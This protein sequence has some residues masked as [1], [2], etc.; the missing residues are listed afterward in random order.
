MCPPNLCLYIV[1]NPPDDVESEF[2]D[3]EAWFLRILA[4]TPVATT[5][6][7]GTGGELPGDLARFAG[8]VVT[9][10]PA[11]L[12]EPEPWMEAGAELVR[13]AAR[14]DT[15]L[16]GVC[17]G[18]QL[19][20]AALG[21]RVI[22]N[23][24]G[25][26]LSTYEVTLLA[27]GQKDPLFRDVPARFPVNLCH[28]DIIAEDPPGEAGKIRAL[29]TTEK[30]ALQV[31]AFG[32]AIRGVQFHPELDGAITRAYLRSREGIVAADARARNATEDQPASLMA[33]IRDCPYAEK[34]FENF[35][36]H[37]LC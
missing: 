17:F 36:R 34:V 11:S 8:F 23:P 32:D 1:G 16:L 12:V 33:R 9:G 35:I 37:W 19:I 26:E 21:G 31:I 28:R 15:P 24:A 3:F 30:T 10:S 20:G 27:E 25:W 14:T 6:F 7:D 4:P 22:A 2:G 18:H 5:V 29:A 13:Y